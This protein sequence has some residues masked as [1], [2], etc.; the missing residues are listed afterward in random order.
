MPRDPRQG[1]LTRRLRLDPQRSGDEGSRADTGLEIAFRQQLRV[2]VEDREAGNFQL[3]SE[4]AAGGNLLA[5]GEVAAQDGIAKACVDLAVQG[6][7]SR[8]VNGDN[9]KDS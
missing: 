3:R 7:V 6:H 2:G 4:R 1:P 8:A 5:G 9:R